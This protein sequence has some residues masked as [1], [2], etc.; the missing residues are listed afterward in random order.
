[1]NARIVRI[2]I[3]LLLIGGG[4]AVGIYASEADKE[5]RVLCGMF[6]PGTFEVEMDRVLGTAQFLEF[7]ES[8]VGDR[9]IRVIHTP[10]NLGRNGCR[11]ELKGG[12]VS[13]NQSWDGFDRAAG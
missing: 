2:V 13:S 8:V 1:M 6:R 11:V 12:V 7:E 9:R 5:V 4:V 3:A 10:W